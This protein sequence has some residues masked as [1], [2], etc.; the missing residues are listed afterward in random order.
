MSAC[1]NWLSTLQ[2]N[3][4]IKQDKYIYWE[5][6]LPKKQLRLQRRIR[7]LSWSDMNGESPL[8]TSSFFSWQFHRSCSW[9]FWPRWE[10]YLYTKKTQ[11]LV[12][13][14]SAWDTGRLPQQLSPLGWP[15]FVWWSLYHKRPGT[16]P[17]EGSSSLIGII[18]QLGQRIHWYL[19]LSI[20]DVY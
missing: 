20:S 9:L 17:L 2:N 12:V 3:F 15:L 4:K 11:V 7:K 1:E 5:S 10:N 13:P 18:S 14:F 19:R 6:L 16:Y 8:T